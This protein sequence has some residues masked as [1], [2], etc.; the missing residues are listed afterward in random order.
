MI[1]FLQPFFSLR[2]WAGTTLSKIYDCPSGTGEAWI[3]SGYKGKGSIIINGE[4]KGI[5]LDVFFDEHPE[6]FDD[7]YKEFP[8]LLKVIDA[9]S[10]LSV[11]VHPD[12]D[13]ADKRHSTPSQKAY[14]KFECWYFL[15]DNKASDVVVGIDA[16][17]KEELLDIINNKQVMSK[18]IKE[19]IKPGSYMQIYP[20]TVHAL[21]GGSLVLETQ[22][23]SDITYR[24]YDYDRVPKRELHIDDSLNVINYNTKTSVQDFS[25]DSTDDN[26]YFT[27]TKEKIKDKISIKV[28]S[29]TIVYVI[30]GNGTLNGLNVSG[31]DCLLLLKEDLLEVIGELEIAIIS[32]K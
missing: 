1:L 8:L 25:S 32:A 28:L 7:K 12:N 23:P 13:Y 19:K 10:D 17:S 3:C 5:A 2:P 27:F 20:G 22:Q 15:E 30:R 24:L 16:S 9:S 11:Q 21:L 26:K 29:L 4:F 18:L 14:G 31:S 6:L